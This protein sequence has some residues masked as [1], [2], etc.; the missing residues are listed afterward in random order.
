MKEMYS[1]ARVYVWEAKQIF[2]QFLQNYQVTKQA[3]LR[4]CKYNIDRFICYK[5]PSKKW[6]ISDRKWNIT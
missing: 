2:S 1:V 3:N 6:R 5:T 4:E